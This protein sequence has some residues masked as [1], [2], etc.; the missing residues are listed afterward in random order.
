MARLPGV[1]SLKFDLNAAFEIL[2]VSDG[3]GRPM[4]FS[5]DKD[6]HTLTVAL[7]QPLE[8]GQAAAVEVYYRGILQ[9]PVQTTDIAQVIPFLD[10]SHDALPEFDSYLY[11]QSASW[12]PSTSDTDFFQ[13]R[14]RISVPPLYS[15]VAVGE[16]VQEETIDEVGRVL[17]LEKIGNRLST[18]ET[19][20]PV[21][22]L[23]FIVGAFKRSIGENGQG[24][25][26]PLKL[27]VSEDI[28][29]V[30]RSMLEEARS[31]LEAF[32]GIFGPF[33]YEKLTIVQRVWGTAG[34]HSPA[35][36]IVL[37]ELAR[38]LNTSAIPDPKSPIDLPQYKE[39]F[40]AHEIAHQWW[41]QT[42][43]GASYH[44]IWLSEGLAQ[45]SAV[46]YLKMKYGPKAFVA[47]MKKFVE[48]T[49][50]ASD[51]GPITLGARLS[52]HDFRSFQAILYGKSVRGPVCAL[53]FD[54]G[55]GLRSGAA[56]LYRTA[57]LRPGPDVSVH[58]GDGGV[59][60]PA[61]PGILP[62]LVRFPSSAPGR[63]GFP[64]PP[65]GRG[66]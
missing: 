57:R 20:K 35:S 63:D 56:P 40:M 38:N 66:L 52:V 7:L 65:P 5:Q 29:I 36:F 41:G 34:G 55:G 31:I 26:P 50:K 62:G 30:R 49:E 17:T 23:A 25:N 10:N 44:D 48:W 13:S 61:A 21:K 27:F 8:K 60:R 18:Y 9:P 3:E 2:R 43:A 39:F 1:E 14:L 58:P 15:T 64:D 47:I 19:R 59:F 28:R 24:E 32:V 46:R 22:Y 6:R 33:P 51:F 11:S 54:R 12:Y 16:L 45:Y 37:N 4:S 53:G 42:V